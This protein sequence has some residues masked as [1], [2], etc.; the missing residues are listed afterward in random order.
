MAAA[1]TTSPWCW[2][3]GTSPACAP[4]DARQRGSGDCRLGFDRL[5]R[6]IPHRPACLLAQRRQPHLVGCRFRLADLHARSRCIDHPLQQDHGGLDRFDSAAEP[7]LALPGRERQV[8]FRQ[9]LRIEQRAMQLAVGVV[10]AQ[11]LAQRIE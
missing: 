8:G 7:D 11:A 3:A 1:R 4:E 9:Q 6:E 2:C 5:D 10:D